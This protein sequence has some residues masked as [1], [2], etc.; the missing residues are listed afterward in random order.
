MLGLTSYSHWPEAKAVRH[1]ALQHAG[2]RVKLT[3]L[4]KQHL[5]GMLHVGLMEQ[6]DASIASLAVGAALI[7][8]LVY[9]SNKMHVH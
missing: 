8:P 3:A 9:Q 5:K 6:I 1:C 2:V 7:H 4:A